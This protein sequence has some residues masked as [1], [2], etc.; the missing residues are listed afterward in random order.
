MNVLLLYLTVGFV[1]GA[2]FGFWTGRWYE[3]RSKRQ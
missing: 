3:L 1:A 2:W